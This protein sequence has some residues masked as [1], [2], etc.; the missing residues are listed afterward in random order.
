M[1]AVSAGAQGLT[2]EQQAQLVR[3]QQA[4][5]EQTQ[6]EAEALQL[7]LQETQRQLYQ[8]Q[9]DAADAE[10]VEI[11][12]SFEW[13]AG[14]GMLAAQSATSGFE[15]E[16]AIIRRNAPKQ[17]EML[18]KAALG[19]VAEHRNTGTAT[20]G[21]VE[22]QNP[23]AAAVAKAPVVV[24][25]CLLVDPSL[26]VISVDVACSVSVCGGRLEQGDVL[27]QPDGVP[28]TVDDDLDAF[29]HSCADSSNPLVVY[30]MTIGDVVIV[31]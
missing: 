24:P 17:L 14:T 11:A 31:E 4:E 13:A 10:S 6:R 28:L 7:Q 29:V 5:N 1:L 22:L 20:L 8:Q 3:A 25:Q 21:S 12:V 16:E 2:P 18:R 27:L 30:R 15:N 19:W 23:F 26:G 9:L